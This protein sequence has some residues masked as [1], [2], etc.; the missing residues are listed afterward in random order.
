MSKFV[1]GVLRSC[2]ERT[3]ALCRRLLEQQL[4]DGASLSVVSG[5]PFEKTLRDCYETAI[6]AGADWTLTVDADLL[7]APGAVDRLLRLAAGMPPEHLQ[8]EGRAFDLIQGRWREVGHRVYRTALLP[9][10]LALLPAPGE[11]IRPESATIK[12]L[13]A[14]G[15]RSR[16]VDSPVGLHDF[17]QYRRDLY[18]KAFTH[19]AKHRSRAGRII[20]RCAD[21]RTA[22][23]DYLVMLKGIWDGLLHQG[24]VQLDAAAFSERAAIA[25]AELGLAEHSELDLATWLA[26]ADLRARMQQVLGE[27]P[28]PIMAPVD[29]PPREIGPVERIGRGYRYR[30]RTRG[31][32]GGN[33]GAVGAILRGLG[34]LLDR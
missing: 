4:P 1:H 20:E 7:L 11:V 22:D 21:R 3:E 33:L 30:L 18:R 16:I 10:A 28:P 34:G 24:P 31:V 2:G 14:Q 6:A 29:E 5:V 27:S 26:D 17:A 32:V 13:G 8:L 12:R 15:H 9:K 23:D 19:A 25:L